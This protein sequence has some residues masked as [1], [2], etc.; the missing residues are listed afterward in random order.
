MLANKFT[1]LGHEVYIFLYDFKG[2]AYTLD[3]KVQIKEIASGNTSRIGKII[4]RV[5]N[6][7]KEVKKIIPDIILAFTIKNIPY[8]LSV[9]FGLQ[10]NVIGLERTNPRLHNKLFQF[11]M[12][13]VSPLCSGFIFQTDGA[14]KCYP[15]LVQKK[16]VVIK[17]PVFIKDIEKKTHVMSVF[18]M[19]S[20]GRLHSDKD[21]ETLIQAFA[22]YCQMGG[23]GILDIYG[24]G[25]LHQ[26]L[27]NKVTK[28]HLQDR[29]KFC[30][31]VKNLH[32]KIKEYD[33]F[34]F[35]SKAEGMPN[36][37][38]E[39][40][41]LGLPCVSSDCDFGP[42]E[43]INSGENGILVPVSDSKKMAEKLF[44][45]DEHCEERIEMG[46]KAEKTAGEWMEDKIVND[47]LEY[48]KSMIKRGKKDVCE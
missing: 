42:R 40:M 19:C 21:F 38:M 45:M 47:Y 41:A 4:F 12:R 30:G 34:V 15:L 1:E 39:A 22:Q 8:A 23:T 26:E 2:I 6:L 44:W 37:L 20:V 7:R 28:L 33:L 35:S 36:A 16:S 27:Q 48:M 10:I 18:R 24:E 32:E 46:K 17:N 29:I 3:D 31:F 11:I 43:L 13:Y 14:R 9:T 25:E 5:K